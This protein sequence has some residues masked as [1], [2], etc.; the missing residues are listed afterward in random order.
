ML[1]VLLAAVTAAALRLRSRDGD[2][3]ER[4]VAAAARRLPADGHDWGR[5]VVAELAVVRGRTR[6]WQFAAGVLRV[7]L[8]PPL[9]R[10][11]AA[12]ATAVAGAFGTVV[13]TAA[14][15]RFVPTLSVFVAAVG[16]LTSGSAAVLA[17]R[18]GRGRGPGTPT[19]LAADAAAVAG[20]LA[21]VVAVVA[22]A[23]A[24]PAATRDRTH[25]FSL[26]LAAVLAGYLVAGLSADR[27]RPAQ[28]AALAGAA[29]SVA[30]SAILP[31]GAVIG[32]VP[33]VTAAA[34]LITAVLVGAVTHS[35]VAAA[36]A[37][38]LAAV[39]GAP[40]HFAMAVA[41]LPAH[42]PTGGYDP[43][44]FAHSGYPDAASYLLGD[45][46]AGNIVSLTVTPLAMYAVAA[47]AA[48]AA[49]GPA[50]GPLTRRPRPRRARPR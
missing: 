10:P 24:H 35:R 13:A 27:T 38:L 43:G 14:A 5:A 44:A 6:R 21:A 29:A 12:G 23:A 11:A 18:P 4:L 2:L 20:L 36:R 46:L 22:L 19:R 28:G 31:A 49:T 8:F 45:A 32:L 17:G 37:G 42:P 16:L 1:L 48:A 40:I 34:T 50:T 47:L 41:R 39:L 3:P 9:A 30:A 7:A 15:A 26:L 25:A 33:P